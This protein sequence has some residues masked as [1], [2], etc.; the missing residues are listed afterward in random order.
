MAARAIVV[1]RHR[2]WSTFL[3]LGIA[4]AVP[5]G[6][7]AAKPQGGKVVSGTATISQDQNT[8][9]ITTGDRAI[10]NWAS[11]DIGGN[12]TVRFAQPGSNSIALNR[13]AAGK[14]SEINGTLTATGQV[15]LVNP[16]GI[17]FGPSSQVDVH[18]IVATTADISNDRFKAGDFRFTKS[19]TDTDAAVVNKGV[20]TVDPN[21]YAVLAGRH[22]SNDGVIVG[23]LST[24]ILAGTP[25]FALDFEGDGLIRFVPNGGGQTLVE[26]AGAI[27]ADGGYVL[28]TASGADRVMAEVINTSGIIEANDAD[29]RDGRVVLQSGSGSMVIDGIADNS[30]I[31]AG[32][33]EIDGRV[34]FV[35]HEVEAQDDVRVAA[36]YV[37]GEDDGVIRAGRLELA[38]IA[39]AAHP[40]GGTVSLATDVDELA[41]GVSG[42]DRSLFGQLELRNEGNLAVAQVGASS[43]INARHIDLQVSGTLTLDQPM[44]VTGEGRAGVVQADRVVNHAGAGAL[45]SPS[46]SFVV[47]SENPNADQLGGVP[48]TPVF[49]GTV[50]TL[51]PDQVTIPGNVFVYPDVPPP[52]APPPA[53]PLSVPVPVTQ[54]T[55]PTVVPS[56][57]GFPAASTQDAQPLVRVVPV[58]SGSSGGDLLFANDGNQEL[59]GLT[60]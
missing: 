23:R 26:N 44:L 31:A 24:V 1:R 58:T 28:L 60:Q 10:L 13:I 29:G 32:D 59:W 33:I 12:E 46:G 17:L 43:G 8:T 25:K 16:S 37:Y 20:I 52:P 42:T 50:A 48:G 35:R 4:V 55:Q 19:A 22:V 9:T 57:V 45:Q 56:Y 5:A 54:V 36:K 47:Y 40:T 34:V 53:P 2:G 51:P 11:F 38:S 30:A 39:P 14:P 7:A 15:W 21:G 6:G 18:G 3:V 27:H 49:G 41:V